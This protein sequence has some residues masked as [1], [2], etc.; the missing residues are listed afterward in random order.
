MKRNSIVLLSAA[1]L[2]LSSAAFADE[3][4]SLS[5]AVASGKA[6]VNV[7]ARYEMVDADNGLKDANALTARLRLNYK[8][9]EWQ[10]WSAFAEYDHVFHLVRDFNSGFGTTP[11]KEGVYQTVVDPKGSDLNQLYLDHGFSD[12]WKLR[13]GR[14]RILLDNERFVGGVGWRQN[15]QTFDALAV[16]TTAISRTSLMYAYVG[17]VRRITGQTSPT[18]S[19]NVDTHLFNAKVTIN[20][21]WS[22]TPYFYYIDNQDAAATSTATLGARLAGNVKA[23]E[24]NTVS[25]VAEL[26]TQSDA[27]N[28][29][30]SYDAGY[31][32]LSAL[33]SMDNGLSLGLAYESLGTDS[34]NSESFRTPLATLHAFQGWADMFLATP[35]AGID[36]LY[37]TVK[38]KAGKWDLTGV[39]HDFSAETGGG[40]FGK[41]F[42][43][44]AGTPI[45]KNYGILF[46]GAFFSSDSVSYVDT[47]KFWIMF[48][49][50]Y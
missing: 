45:S 6:G 15:E 42:D 10:G 20:D 7:R 36:D 38:Y 47:N 24:G 11:D 44:S 9:G 12:D 19:W 48:T 37:A 33:W 23:G 35:G 30:A 41:E 1:S 31:A 27:G 22:V 18:G 21:N 13:V 17:Q 32:H 40:D 49:A 3:S 4:T 46:K 26:A 39:Y 16:T 14:Q 5:S 8:T 34:A 2:L 43:L 25:L 28:N 50:N 29:P